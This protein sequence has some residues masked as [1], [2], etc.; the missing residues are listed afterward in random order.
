MLEPISRLATALCARGYR[1][2][3]RPARPCWDDREAGAPEVGYFRTTKPEGHHGTVCLA[4]DDVFGFALF[5]SFEHW[6]ALGRF[7]QGD[8]LIADARKGES[9]EDR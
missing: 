2:G 3:S 6:D 8:A 9:C 1:W 4:D 5:L 7:D